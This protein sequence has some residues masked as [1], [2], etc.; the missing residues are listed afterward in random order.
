MCGTSGATRSSSFF[1]LGRLS[2]GRYGNEQTK[3]NI[4]TSR[5]QEWSESVA[6]GLCF[7][8]CGWLCHCLC[9]LIW[10]PCLPPTA[11]APQ[12]KNRGMD[13]SRKVTLS[14]L[15]VGTCVHV[16]VRSSSGFLCPC[17][18]FSLFAGKRVHDGP[19]V[20]TAPSFAV[21]LAG[22]VAVWL[23]FA[24]PHTSSL[25]SR[26]GYLRASCSLPRL[27]RSTRWPLARWK[28]CFAGEVV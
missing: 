15:L 5:I 3:T 4:G 14:N 8:F 23:G 18:Q 10:C 20:S 27:C 24:Q 16:R 22:R 28:R 1:P 2:Q 11:V 9:L 17:G 26:W 25:L 19:L 7:W 6:V 12:S 13:V 21:L